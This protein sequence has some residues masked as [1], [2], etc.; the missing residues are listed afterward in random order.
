MQAVLGKPVGGRNR[1]ILIPGPD[2]A[3]AHVP[4]LPLI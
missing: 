1:E 3:L 4:Q 2:A